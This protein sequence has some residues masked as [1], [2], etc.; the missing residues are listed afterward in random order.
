MTYIPDGNFFK[1]SCQD[2]RLSRKAY[3]TI[4]VTLVSLLA[5]IK[6]CPPDI[7]MLGA[8]LV[9]LLWPWAGVVETS[10]GPGSR[11]GIITEAE[12]WQGFSNT[13]VLTVG[14]LFVVARAVDETG[15]VERF[16]KRILGAPRSLFIAQCRL[17]FPVA[18]CR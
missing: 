6:D 13:G 15:A 14:A 17:L 9:L 5:M 12:A 18:I 10:T 4:A 11:R 3:V 1:L 7:C 16:M 8:T 2:A